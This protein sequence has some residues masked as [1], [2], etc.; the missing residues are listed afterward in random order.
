MNLSYVFLTLLA[1]GFVAVLA[2]H[3]MYRPGSR[4]RRRRQMARIR[5][6]TQARRDAS[7]IR[8]SQ[9]KQPKD[10]DGIDCEL[11]TPWGWG[12]RQDRHLLDS[13][14]GFAQMIRQEKKLTSN[15]AYRQH[16]N[17]SLKKMV[18]DRH[19]SR[20]RRDSCPFTSESIIAAT[21][22]PRPRRVVSHRRLQTAAQRGG[23]R[24]VNAALKIANVQTPWGW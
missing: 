6:N 14:H 1:L 12:G 11:P 19:G 4:W 5:K 21:K 2:L 13:L 23:P 24:S 22:L 18:E 9:E 17:D 20:R 16:C 15:P 8:A 10:A 7:Q 3:T